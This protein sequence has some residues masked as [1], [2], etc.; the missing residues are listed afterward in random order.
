LRR[1]RDPVDA[2]ERLP[3]GIDWIERIGRA[4]AEA[5]ESQPAI[6][7]LASPDRIDHCRHDRGLERVRCRDERRPADATDDRPRAVGD[8]PTDGLVR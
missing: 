3:C 4:A 8:Q 2:A 6:R 5:R 1:D 7:P